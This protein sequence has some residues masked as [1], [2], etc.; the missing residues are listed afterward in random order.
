MTNIR[1]QHDKNRPYVVLNKE[2]LSNTNLSWAAKGLWS[3]L[4]S[5]P[6]DWHVSVNHLKTIYK[7]H[8]GGR[9]AIRQYLK[10]LEEEGY[11]EKIQKKNSDG[12][13]CEV[14]YVIHELKKSL[15]QTE[16][17][18]PESPAPVDHPLLSNDCLPSKKETTT[19]A[20]PVAVFSCLKD[21]AI[22][23]KEK[24]WLCKNYDEPTIAYA[25]A[26]VSHPDFVL[27]KS[28][29]QAIKWACKEKPEIPKLK[30]EI[31]KENR[32]WIEEKI[33]SVKPSQYHKIEILRKEVE[34]VFNGQK[35]PE[36]ISYDDKQFKEKLMR[37]LK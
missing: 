16:L 15:P 27:K 4:L 28:L 37:Y 6:D 1:I 14:E 19:A 34:I 29:A 33:K 36:C 5:L 8:G 21:T 26:V 24:L 35:E 3:Y 25:V 30:E 13:F 11:C 2:C 9:D 17:P 31:A 12:T 18:A 7:D 22:S 23:D 10:E 32:K 20:Q